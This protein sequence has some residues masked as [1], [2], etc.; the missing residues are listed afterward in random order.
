M[1][2]WALHVLGF[3]FSCMQF[4]MMAVFANLSAVPEQNA[5]HQQHTSVCYCHWYHIDGLRAVCT[6]E[7]VQAGWGVW[8]PASVSVP[9]R[10]CLPALPQCSL[11]TA[12]CSCHI[13]SGGDCIFCHIPLHTQQYRCT[14][15]VW[16]PQEGCRF[17]SVSVC[18]SLC[19][20]RENWVR[21]IS[22]PFHITHHKILIPKVTFAGCF[23]SPQLKHLL[24]FL[25]CWV[26][27]AS[28]KRNGRSH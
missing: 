7:Y 14:H 8:S 12:V 19:D 24:P 13:I 20:A 5:V 2:I 10:Q 15:R 22:F 11:H 6:A 18:N 28:T 3:A 27:R 25:L 9:A 21:R 16:W 17:W 4:W 26:A 1:W 23:V